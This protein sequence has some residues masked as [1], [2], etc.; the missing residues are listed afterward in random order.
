VYLGETRLIDNFVYQAF[1]KPTL[2][3]P[4]RKAGIDPA[5]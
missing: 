4:D 5:E 3:L 1:Q 2:Q